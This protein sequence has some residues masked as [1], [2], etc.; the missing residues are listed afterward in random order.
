MSP[1]TTSGFALRALPDFPAYQPS[2]FVVD[3]SFQLKLHGLELE[4]QTRKKSLSNIDIDREMKR[5]AMEWE[6]EDRKRGRELQELNLEENRRAR[7]EAAQARAEDRELRRQM[8]QSKERPELREAGGIVYEYRNGQMVPLTPEPTKKTAADAVRAQQWN[9]L[10]Q[11]GTSLGVDISRYAENNDLAGATNAV[12]TAKQGARATALGYNSLEEYQTA[13]STKE[14]RDEIGRRRAAL[15]GRTDDAAAFLASI[16]LGDDNT[17]APDATPNVTAPA[18]ATP[19]IPTPTA[20]TPQLDRDEDIAAA[21]GSGTLAVG[22]IF[23]SGGRQ[24]RVTQAM[25]DAIKGTPAPVS[26]PVAAPQQSIPTSTTPAPVTPV[27][28]PERAIPAI[29]ESPVAQ[30]FLEDVRPTRIDTRNMREG[31]KRT[32]AA[33][34]LGFNSVSEAELAGRGNDVQNLALNLGRSR[35]DRAAQRRER[36]MLETQQRLAR[37]EALRNAIEVGRDTGDWSAAVQ[38]QDPRDWPEEFSAWRMQAITSRWR[39]ESG[40]MNTPPKVGALD[41]FNDAVRQGLL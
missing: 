30:D 38:I 41:G 4:N 18:I 3:P 29:A 36:D 10:A 22:S 17:P 8:A 39:R 28:E 31:D 11:Q 32:V 25:V 13:L 2:A 12:N 20:Q 26:T 24:F 19:A 23:T 37:Q 35:E 34:Q 6:M 16:G 27:I 40:S 14:G 7:E 33:Q 9:V 1:I 21:I 15:A 5:Q